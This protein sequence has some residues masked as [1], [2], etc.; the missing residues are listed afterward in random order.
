MAWLVLYQVPRIIG[1]VR[2]NSRSVPFS[3]T[4]TL[5]ALLHRASDAHLFF[6]YSA[7]RV[8]LFCTIALPSPQPRE[9]RRHVDKIRSNAQRL[10]IRRQPR[11]RSAE[12]KAQVSS[13]GIGSTCT[14]IRPRW[15]WLPRIMWSSSVPCTLLL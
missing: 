13:R 8:H 9:V 12:M 10:A 15:S 11:Q 14:S 2:E 4:L 1:N 7:L 3:R 6:F 5:P